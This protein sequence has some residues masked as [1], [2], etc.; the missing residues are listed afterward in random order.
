M[1]FDGVQQGGREW[2][3]AFNRYT[4]NDV[5]D[6]EYTA[7]NKTDFP[8]W[9]MVLLFT[10]RHLLYSTQWLEDCIVQEEKV[11]EKPRLTF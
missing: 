5:L 9:A 1:T 4:S 3:H 8:P 2:V 7:E 10:S 6:T 11:E